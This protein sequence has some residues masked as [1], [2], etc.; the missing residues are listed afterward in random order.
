VSPGAAKE[1]IVVLS[2]IDW[3]TAWQRHQIFAALLAEAGHDV[4]FV[5][6]MGFR[7]PGLKDL[8]RVWSRLAGFVRAPE[9]RST[10][11]APPGLRVIAP[12]VLPPTFGSFRALNS[13]VFI[14]NLVAQLKASGLRD[15][16]VAIVYH[17]T[18]STLAAVDALRPS[19]VIYDCASNFRGHPDAPADFARQEEG[20]LRRSDAVVCDSNFLFEQKKA[21]HPRVFQIHQGVSEEFFKAAPP[22]PSFRRLCYYGTWVPELNHE[23]LAALAED[24]FEVT[25]SGFMK[26]SPPPLPA[27]VRRLPPAP[28]EKLV[29]RLENFDAVLLPHRITPFMLGV[30]PAKLYEIM[31]MGRP[32]I[33]TPLPS[34]AALK[35]LV[36]VGETPADWVRIARALPRTETSARREARIALAREHTHHREFE[37]F[38]GVLSDALERRRASLRP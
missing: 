25:I 31:A 32:V 38:R 4:F 20:L 9:A 19:V 12:K 21:E 33:A 29:E 16:P 18:P 11:P 15:S 13:A 8:P 35:E 7:N 28:R 22:S 30:V 34:V 6:N 27:S 24:G 14:P 10:N 2:S 1:Q 36:Y 5:N 23:F 26:G 37:R 3:D 17:A